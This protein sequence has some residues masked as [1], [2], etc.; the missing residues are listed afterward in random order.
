MANYPGSKDGLTNIILGGP[1]HQRAA[2]RFKALSSSPLAAIRYYAMT[3]GAGY[4]AGTGGRLLYQLCADVGGLPGAVIA[5]GVLLTDLAYPEWV[6]KGGF[7]LVGFPTLPRLTAGQWYHFQLINIDPAPLANYQ[8]LNVM[9][10]A[11]GIN[12]DPM[13]SVLYRPAGSPWLKGTTVISGR[14]WDMIAEP[15]GIFY[16]NGDAQGNGGYQI[17]SNGSTQCGTEYGFGRLC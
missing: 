10:S 4:A 13:T 9:I 14:T 2:L 6:N 1:D 5:G 12:P 3:Q 7:P 11:T 15:F 17:A 16:A 8:S